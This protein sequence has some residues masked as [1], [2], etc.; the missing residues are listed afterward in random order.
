MT[1]VDVYVVD[2]IQYTQKKVFL[3]CCGCG[4]VGDVVVNAVFVSLCVQYLTV[5]RAVGTVVSPRW[6]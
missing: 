2:V 3:L 6:S 4:S 1:V 5:V